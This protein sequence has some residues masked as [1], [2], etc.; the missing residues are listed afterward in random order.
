[1]LRHGQVLA[2][3]IATACIVFTPAP[4]AVADVPPGCHVAYT[5][6]GVA[7]LV[8]ENGDDRPAA[9]P[10]PPAAPAGSERGSVGSDNDASSGVQ[11][12]TTYPTY[13][14]VRCLNPPSPRAAPAG[15][16]VYGTQTPTS[17]VMICQSGVDGGDPFYFWST[18]AAAP[19]P[20]DLAALSRLAR[21][22]IVIPQFM[23][24]FGPDPN[25]LAVNMETTFTAVPNGSTDLSAS[26]TDQGITVTVTGQLTGMSWSPGEP[27]NCTPGKRDE[28]CTGGDVGSV[29]CPGTACQYTYHWVSS[30]ARTG[31]EPV[32]IVAVN[33]QWQ[34]SYSTSG[35][36]TTT[37]PTTAIWTE[38]MPAGTGTVAMGEWSTVGGYG[39]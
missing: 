18:P 9:T 36:G 11:N 38:T 2:S 3:V 25:R 6:G 5:V 26:A 23:L 4:A 16:T 31:G 22:T 12:Q 1:M 29:G 13:N 30:T 33:A 7:T 37:G 28:P 20:V 21:A 24:Q 32:W 14:E 10:T 34:F 35:G 39:N 19:P 15:A 17:V 27:V 8:C